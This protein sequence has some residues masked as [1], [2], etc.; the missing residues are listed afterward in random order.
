[1]GWTV[2]YSSTSALLDP[3]QMALATSVFP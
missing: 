2:P 3:P 1:M